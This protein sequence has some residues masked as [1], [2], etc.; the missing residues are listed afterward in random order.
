MRVS[1]LVAVVALT[2]IAFA[3]C[4]DGQDTLTDDELEAQA[5]REGFVQGSWPSGQVARDYIESYVMTHPFR[6]S[7][8]QYEEYMESARDDLQ[9]IMESHGLVVERHEYVTTQKVTSSAPDETAQQVP[10]VSLLGFQYGTVNPD[11]WVVL[12]AHYD[13]ASN[14]EAGIGPTAY[15]AWDDGAGVATLL[16]LSEAFQDWDFPF[17]VVYAM[18]DQEEEG[19]V[20]SQQFVQNYLEERSEIDVLANL[21][22]DPPGLNWPCGD[23]NGYF[24]VKIIEQMEH[25]GNA[26]LPRYAWLN[27]AMEYALNASEVPEEVRDQTSGIPIATFRDPNPLVPDAPVVNEPSAPTG[28]R[29]TSDHA[30]FGQALIAN[31][32]IGGIPV[33][34]VGGDAD[35]HDAAAMTYALHT[36]L[37]T[38]QQME[39]RCTV[40]TLADGL[41]TI[42][43]IFAHA[44]SHLSQTPPPA[45]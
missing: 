7:Q 14:V 40:G 9:V 22:T 21:N 25:V 30:S 3:G 35:N 37:D 11:Q 6:A 29:G 5:Y 39:A 43:D 44:L 12:S 32:F 10:G 1:P 24:S 18:F 36:P 2:A 16:A 19:L 13:T 15:G 45:F 8:P 23:Q 31:V 33:T 28:V 38:L 20:G 26:T 17:T 42:S 41:Q 27:E 4:I 34:I